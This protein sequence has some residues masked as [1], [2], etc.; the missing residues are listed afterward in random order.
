M[1]ATITYANTAQRSV[2]YADPVF[3]AR[4]IPQLVLERYGT[5]KALPKNKTDNITFKRAIPFDVDIT[6]LQEGVTPGPQGYQDEQVSVSIKQYGKWTQHTDKFED[7]HEDTKQVI[8]EIAAMHGEQCGEMKE[9]LTWNTLRGGTQ[10]FYGST[11]ATPTARS[12]VNDVIDANIQARIYRR[13]R[14]NRGL[15]TQPSI[16]A[17]TGI[18]TEPVAA[19]Y[20]AFGHTDLDE[21]IRDLAGF[22]PYEKYSKGSGLMEHEIGKSKQFRYVLTPTLEPFRGAGST[23]INGMTATGANVDAYPIVYIAKDA[24][25]IVPLKGRESCE[26][27]FQSAGVKTETDPLGQRGFSSWR[28]WYAVVRLNEQWMARAE[29]GATALT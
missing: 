20:C 7:T 23:T 29:V 4:A 15:M 1:S 14:A 10:V 28:L 12:D 5:V 13:L 9:L 24:F 3:L 27:H 17:G 18:A 16:S 11:A 26:M 8:A 25:G 2:T 22:V 6:E 19:A 21:D